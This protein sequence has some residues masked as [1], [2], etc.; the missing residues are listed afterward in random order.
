MRKRNLL[1]SF[2]SAFDGFFYCRKTQRTFR[3][4][5]LATILVLILAYCLK[6]ERSEFLILLLT[7][8]LVLTLEM[9]NT[10]FESLVDIV[11][12]EWK[13]KAMI[14]KDVA[15][16]AVLLAAVFAIFIGIIIFGRQT[17]L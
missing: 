3:F 13:E 4:H 1:Q 15:A 10:A 6:I 9:I 17:F 11:A 5:L 7:I 2:K 14:A 12:P 16:G 8:L